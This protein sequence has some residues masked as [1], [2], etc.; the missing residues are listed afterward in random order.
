MGHKIFKF[1]AIHDVS[2]T[3]A[4]AVGGNPSIVDYI[5]LKLLLTPVALLL[6]SFKPLKW[7]RL[8]AALMFADAAYTSFIL[9]NDAEFRSTYG[10]GTNLN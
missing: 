7:L 9:M 1:D 8:P 10:T 2:I 6:S 5:G 4:E 3:T